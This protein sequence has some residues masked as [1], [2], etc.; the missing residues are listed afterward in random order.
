MPT[1]TSN[2][3]TIILKVAYGYT[4]KEGKEDPFVEL[5]DKVMHV[6]SL[7]A[8]PGAYIVDTIPACKPL[9]QCLQLS[10]NSHVIKVR[11]L[12]EWFPGA[13]FFEEAKRYRNYVTES[14]SKPHQWVMQ[15]MVR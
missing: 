14:V 4:V 6:I 11:Y 1:S 3:G 7:V 8:N 12:P 10:R 9:S 15:Q 5:A 13:T 2:A